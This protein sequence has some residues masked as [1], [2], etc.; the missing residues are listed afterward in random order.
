MASY[1][2]YNQLL[3][4]GEASFTDDR[5]VV[6]D[7]GG[8]ARVASFF[9]A[10]KHTFKVVHILNE[11]DFDAWYAFYLANRNLEVSFTS[12]MDDETYA[13]VFSTSGVAVQKLSGGLFKVTVSLEEV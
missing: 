6:R 2:S 1:P 12:D 11:A 8:G 10:P 4:D 13:C 7:S 3:A 5:V 9:D